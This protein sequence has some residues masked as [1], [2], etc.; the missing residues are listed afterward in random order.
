MQS[1]IAIL[2]CV[3]ALVVSPTFAAKSH[4]RASAFK[5]SPGTVITLTKPLAVSA[6]AAV[7]IVLVAAVALPGELVQ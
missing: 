5:I 6:T 2:F 4:S 7:G 3:L 1:T